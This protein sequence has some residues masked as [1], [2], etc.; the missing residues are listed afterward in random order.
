MKVRLRNR[1]REV[2]QL[3]EDVL[4]AEDSDAA[5]ERG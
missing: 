3:S 4:P 5:A 2:G 1:D